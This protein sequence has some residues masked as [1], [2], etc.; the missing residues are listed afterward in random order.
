VTPIKR[1]ELIEKLSI[2]RYTE[3]LNGIAALKNITA[4]FVTQDEI[5]FM[6]E[7]VERT[8]VQYMTKH[9]LMIELQAVH[10]DLYSRI[11]E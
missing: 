2:Y 6:W 11:A 1:Q 7:C 3:I 10:I 5:Q 8:L 4:E 9:N